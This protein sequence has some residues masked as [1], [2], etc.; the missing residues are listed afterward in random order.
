[1]SVGRGDGNGHGRLTDMPNALYGAL[2]AATTATP[3]PVARLPVAAAVWVWPVQPPVVTRAFQPPPTPYA[4]GH[5][6]LDLAAVAGQAVEAAGAGVVSFAGHVAGTGVVVVRHGVLR[7]TYEPVEPGVSVGQGVVA[8]D[9]LGHISGGH[10]GCTVCLHF[11][12]KRG[13]EYLDPMLLFA[14]GPVRLIPVD[15]PLP[16]LPPAAKVP[17]TP[18]EAAVTASGV[19][20]SRPPTT[21]GQGGGAGPLVGAGAAA[22]AATVTSM[23]VMRDRRRRRPA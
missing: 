18:V 8:G 7:T 22:A 11:G 13:E 2:L 10:L 16:G 12:L 17:A 20:V 9:V 1:M 3:P 5:R 14:R 23:S 19:A 4:A 21:A 6:G 15:G